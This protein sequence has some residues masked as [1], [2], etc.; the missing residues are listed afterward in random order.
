MAFVV[1]H[2]GGT[3]KPITTTAGVQR[4]DARSLNGNY[5]ITGGAGTTSSGSGTRPTAG[6]LWPRGTKP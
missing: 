4:P 1:S 5:K 6:Q 3:P 2:G